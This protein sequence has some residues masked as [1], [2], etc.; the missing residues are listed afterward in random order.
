MIKQ[1]VKTNRV[2]AKSHTKVCVICFCGRVVDHLNAKLMDMSEELVHLKQEF[3]ESPTYK[4]D[5]DF[6]KRD[7]IEVNEL[8]RDA[9][10]VSAR[11]FG[12]SHMKT[13]RM[14]LEELRKWKR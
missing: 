8:I 14:G 4:D 2:T 1:K 3:G 13:C 6:L 12:N 7:I 11:I 10:I 9:K 5:I